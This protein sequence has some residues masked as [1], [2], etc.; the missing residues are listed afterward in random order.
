[1]YSND[2]E[3]W[4]WEHKSSPSASHPV[5]A[6][7]ESAD[8]EDFLSIKLEVTGKNNWIFFFTFQ[9]IQLALNW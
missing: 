6:N 2:M 9:Q 1:M 5:V 3:I 4:L 7:A 8:K